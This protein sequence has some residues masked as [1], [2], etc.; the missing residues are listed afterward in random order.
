MPS[1]FHDADLAPSTDVTAEVTA[2]PSVESEAPDPSTAPDVPADAESAPG[3]DSGSAQP[4]ADNGRFAPKGPST[5]SADA[6]PPAVASPPGSPGTTPAAPV[7]PPAIADRPFTVRATGQVHP[8]D[9]AVLQGD[10]S[11]KVAPDQVGL[12]KQL[13]SEGLHHR[14]THRQREQEFTSRVEEATKRGT[15][16][17]TR[18]KSLFEH[19]YQLLSN[20]EALVALANGYDERFPILKDRLDVLFDRASLQMPRE[21][22]KAAEDP[23]ASERAV[24]EAASAAFHEELDDF[25]EEPGYASVFTGEELTALRE[26]MEHRWT[27]YFTQ[28]EG[29]TVLDRHALKAELDYE[30]KL[31]TRASSNATA[32]AKAAAANATRSAPPAVPSVVPARGSPTPSDTATKP[33][34]ATWAREHGLG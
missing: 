1:I 17:A 34:R 9:G 31:R 21:A 11:L 12:V 33:D 15:A 4:R 13:L 27:S 28:H 6:A 10:G 30:A 19:T 29:E 18:W 14:A 26:R 5:E 3:A 24:Q 25:L 2:S 8:I 7:A 32:L 23:Q 20:P 22:P 16:D